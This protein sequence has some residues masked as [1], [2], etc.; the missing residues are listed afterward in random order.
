MAKTTRV[1]FEGIW[2]HNNTSHI[3][4][5]IGNKAITTLWVESFDDGIATVDPTPGC[6][7]NDFAEALAGCF[8]EKSNFGTEVMMAYNCDENATFTGIQFTFNGVTLTVT[9]DN[10]D[11]DT[12]CKEWHDGME[13]NAEKHRREKE[14]WLQTPEGQ[15]YLAQQK[16]EE[17]RRKAVEAEVLQIDDT[18]E[19]E[20]K[21][22][23]AKKAWD[24]MVEVNSKDSYGMGVVKYARRWAKCMQK[25]IAEGKTVI[26]IAEKTSHD[27]DIEGITGFMY[28][29]A[30]QA[31]SKSWK[32]GEELRKWHNKNY[33][34]EGDRVVNPA[35]LTIGAFQ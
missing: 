33:G 28:G 4:Q 18:I 6:N 20:F 15:E 2:E 17:I 26:E 34:Y 3:F 9:K 14:A 7:I 11:K 31:L 35:V 22:D 1:Y 21:D 24:D 29:C 12:I 25:L 30:V 23:E 8:D 19:M 13:A 10:A 27:C 5:T 32:Y 16:A